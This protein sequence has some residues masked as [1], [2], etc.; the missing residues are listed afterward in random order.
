MKEKVEEK[1]QNFTFSFKGFVCL[2]RSSLSVALKLG[3][4]FI[5]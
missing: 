2:L 4:T 5:V 1:K 3:F